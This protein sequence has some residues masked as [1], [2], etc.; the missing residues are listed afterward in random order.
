MSMAVKDVV[1]ELQDLT[2]LDWTESVVSSAAGGSYLKARTGEGPE[3]RYYNTCHTGFCAR[4]C[5]WAAKT[6]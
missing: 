2:H 3:A 6:I 5:A 1:P 4:A